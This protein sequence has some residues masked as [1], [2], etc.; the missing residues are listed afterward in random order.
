MDNNL[1][2][3][4]YRNIKKQRIRLGMTQTELAE[5]VGYSDKSMIAKIESGKIDIPVSKVIT[6]AEALHLSPFNLMGWNNSNDSAKETTCTNMETPINSQELS[7]RPEI[8]ILFSASK[9]VKAE[10]L[11]K[12]AEYLE[13][14][15]WREKRAD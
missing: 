3:D 15:K 5:K 11:C 6:F 4:L 12:A 8:R 10:D 13:F 7:D 1:C 9:D 2:A 14:L